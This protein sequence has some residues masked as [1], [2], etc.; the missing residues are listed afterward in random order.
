MGLFSDGAVFHGEDPGVGEILG[1]G[2][3]G[4]EDL[5]RLDDAGQEGLFSQ[6][7]QLS[8]HIVHQDGDPLVWMMGVE[9]V[10]QSQPE[11]EGGG[12]AFS[13]GAVGGEEFSLEEAGQVASLGAVRGSR[14]SRDLEI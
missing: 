4:E 3:S 11:G 14:R 6:G 1:E 5:P 2:G 7:I 13:L 10:E 12:A 9:G 8:Q